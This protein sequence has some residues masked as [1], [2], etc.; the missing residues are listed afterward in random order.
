M[1][2]GLHSLDNNDLEYLIGL[3]HGGGGGAG[4]TGQRGP[5]GQM[6]L[7]GPQGPMGLL[8]PTGQQGATGAGPT[9]Q[10]GATGPFGGPPGPTGQQG[11]TGP[12]GGPPGPTGQ[13][14][15]TGQPGGGPTGQIGPTGPVFSLTNQPIA[16]FVDPQNSTGFANNTNTGQTAN[17]VP[18]GSGPILSTDEENIRIQARASLGPLLADLTIT[19]LS[20][21]FGLIGLDLSYLDQEDFNIV[22][23]MT[24]VLMHPGG[25]IN[26]GTIAIDPLAPGGGQR[27]TAHTSD[28]VDF[29]PFVFTDAQAGGGA[30]V[31]TRIT[32]TVTTAGSWIAGGVGSATASVTR[33]MLPD[34]QTPGALTLGDAYQITRPGRLKL[35][36]VPPPHSSGGV[37]TFNDCAF[38]VGSIGP[39]DTGSFSANI[40]F[41]TRC[42]FL[43]PVFNGGT[44]QDCAWCSGTQGNYIA[45]TFAG[46]WL[47]NANTD[48]T[49]GVINVNADTYVTGI[50]GSLTVG[51]TFVQNLDVF[52][53][54]QIQDVPGNGIDIT[55]GAT[56]FIIAPIWG[57]GNSGFGMNIQQAAQI[58]VPSTAG[59]RP[60][61]TGASGDLSFADVLGATVT[62]AATW[63]NSTGLATPVASVLSWAN[64]VNPAIYN[65][66]AHCLSAGAE[67][68]ANNF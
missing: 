12:S 36:S 46:L 26:A 44:Y 20:E 50:N 24:P 37:L 27:Q 6:G 10:Q 18:P 65:F 42:A 57:N 40:T 48:Q 5:T 63:N 52:G 45:N 38:V 34:G 33:P 16:L 19:Y 23:Q 53:G 3:K 11:P 29:T 58:V 59:N 4:P 9:G 49:V 47:P 7:Q 41:Y 15:P 21:S 32:D 67:I 54:I 30:T 25:T 62:T 56:M 66:Q 64:F 22:V 13:Q 43:G 61:V 55:Q 60:S 28:V 2:E 14:G 35:A 1:V 51:Q 8:G 31:P 17:N 39:R 68:V